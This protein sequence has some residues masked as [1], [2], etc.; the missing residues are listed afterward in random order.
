[1]GTV[2][3]RNSFLDE[4]ED[5]DSI[6]FEKRR[7][8][9]ALLRSLRLGACC[10]AI[11]MP[12]SHDNDPAI[13]LRKGVRRENIDTIE[14]VP[15]THA[16]LESMGFGVTTTPMELGKALVHYAKS[17]RVYD[18][19]YL[20]LWGLLSKKYLKDIRF[21]FG[22][23]NHGGMIRRPGTLMVTTGFS[24][25]KKDAVEL[26][27]QARKEGW[28]EEYPATPFHLRN[29]LMMSGIPFR[30]IKPY[31]YQSFTHRQYVVTVVSF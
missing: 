26:E 6:C 29:L 4:N 18:L 2:P 14:K 13:L 23:E 20:D 25:A 16:Y 24:R 3:I 12:G 10:R 19:I 11:L 21:I 30:S 8:T 22:G 17:R 1:M 7:V 31:P 15:E 5:L 27:E 28:K 9:N